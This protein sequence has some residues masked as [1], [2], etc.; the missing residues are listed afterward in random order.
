M[1]FEILQHPVLL[2][3]WATAW[4]LSVGLHEAGHAYS[5]DRLGDPTPG[6]NGRLTLN[7]FAHLKPVMTAVILPAILLLSGNGIMGAALTP[8]NPSYYRRPLRDQ[9]LVAAA[10]P[11]VNILLALLAAGAFRLFTSSSSPIVFF[12]IVMVQL[13]VI[14][15]LINL[16]PIPGLDGGNIFRAGLGPAAREKFDAAR[17]YGLIIAIVVLSLPFMHFSWLVEKITRFLLFGMTHAG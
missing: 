9:A 13:N 16:L 11:A 14:L 3:S 8:T 7:P 4:I 6:L 15:I 10:G 2:L 12:L 17:Q 1:D 5:A